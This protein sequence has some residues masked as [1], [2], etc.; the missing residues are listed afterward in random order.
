M[1]THTDAQKPAGRREIIKASAIVCIAGL[2]AA[3][4]GS[5]WRAQGQTNPLQIIPL[6]QGVSTE[7][8]VELKAHGPNDVLQAL[9]VFQPGA[10]TGWHVHP[11]PVVVV[12]KTGTLTEETKNG[13][14]VQH[15]AGS[16]FFEQK[17]EVHRAFNNGGTAAEVYGTF[18]LPSGAQP[19]I[20]KPDPHG[21][22]RH[23]EDR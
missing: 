9:L 17:D 1:T 10:D 15:P 2:A 3:A 19:L 6:A 5:A 21:T 11:G 22:C 18:L 23:G 20:P 8:Q 13:C 12:V 16:V 7:R 4:A 14:L